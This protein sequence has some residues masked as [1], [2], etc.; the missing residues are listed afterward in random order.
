MELRRWPRKNDPGS[1]RARQEALSDRLDGER[2]VF[3]HDLAPFTKATEGLTG[4][5]MV[6]VA[7]V[8]PLD[9]DVGRYELNESDGRLV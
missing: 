7:V 8:G 3:S 5:A 4:G 2:E 1:I 6:P 9:V